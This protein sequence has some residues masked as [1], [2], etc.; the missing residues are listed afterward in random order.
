[1]T[2]RRRFEY[3]P[4]QSFCTTCKRWIQLRSV[5]DWDRHKASR[6]HLRFRK[7]FLFG[8]GSRAAAKSS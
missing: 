4:R 8:P 2:V 5:T 7:K 3:G 6:T 1:M